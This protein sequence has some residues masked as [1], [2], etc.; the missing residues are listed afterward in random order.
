MSLSHY[1]LKVTSARTVQ[2]ALSNVASPVSNAALKRMMESV[3]QMMLP[4]KF[5]PQ[6]LASYLA[7]RNERVSRLPSS[8][9]GLFGAV[10]GVNQGVR[11]NEFWKYSVEK[12]SPHI[13]FVY[14][15]IRLAA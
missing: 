13:S 6:G 4:P 15:F 5:Y 14:F 10:D 1:F 8:M 11:F 2:D 7:A 9:Q 3:P 12:E